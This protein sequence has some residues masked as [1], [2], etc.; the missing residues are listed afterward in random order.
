MVENAKGFIC[1]NGRMHESSGSKVFFIPAY[2]NV[3]ISL[4]AVEKECTI[5]I[6]RFSI[7]ESQFRPLINGFDIAG[8]RDDKSNDNLNIIDSFKSAQLI[9]SKIGDISSLYAL[10]SLAMV[11]YI[12]NASNNEIINVISFP[13][14]IDRI[15]NAMRMDITKKWSAEELSQSANMTFTQLHRVLYKENITFN[16]LLNIIRLKHSIRLLYGGKSI[17]TSAYNSGFDCPNYYSRVFKK[18]YGFSPSEIRK[19]KEMSMMVP[20]L[21]L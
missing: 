17:K 3:G 2:T 4:S 12:R 15:A 6:N 19:S 10:F 9:S 21:T 14:E 1:I 7:E 18:Y 11:Q 13:H 20:E 5:N 8:I 16:Q